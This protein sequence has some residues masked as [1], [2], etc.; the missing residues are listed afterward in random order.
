VLVSTYYYSSS[1]FS[2]FILPRLTATKNPNNI[3]MALGL[4]LTTKQGQPR[5]GGEKGVAS[6]LLWCEGLTY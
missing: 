6:P 3:V 5:L 4:A 1:T 2:L